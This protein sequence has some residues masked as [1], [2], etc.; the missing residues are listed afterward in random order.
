MKLKQDDIIN[1]KIIDLGMDGEG[2]GKIEDYILFIPFALIGEEVKAKV[3]YVKKN[4]VFC[5]LIEVITP[6]EDR[7]IP[8]CN[9]F[10]KCGG[11]DLLHLKYLKQLEWKKRS[12]EVLLRKNAGII[13]PV[14]DTVA[15]S[16]PNSYR[17]KIQLPFGM[18][19]GKVA[20]GFF[21]ENTHKIV[22]ITKCFLHGEWAEKLINIFISYA[23]E[24]NLS[25][26]DES[27]KK[28]ILR[29]MVA[30]EI[31]RQLTIVVVTN[32]SVLP[33]TDLLIKKL[34]SAFGANYALY[35]S[36]KKTHDNVIMG[37]TVIPIKEKKI[38]TDILG[39]KTEINPFS[40]LQLNNE[41][42]DKIY[43]KV[44]NEICKND[45]SPLVIDA[46]A[47]VGIIGAV[48]AKN[49]AEAYNIEIV[50]EATED[51]IKLAAE[52]NLKD[53]IT[54]INGDAAQELPK[55][56]NCLLANQNNQSRTLNIILDPPRKGCAPEVLYAISSLSIPHNVYYIS[57]NPATLSRD[58]KL[59]P[60]HT[61]NSITPYDMF[62][63]TKHLETLVCL[64]RKWSK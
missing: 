47:G 26:Y 43:L 30:R 35:Y 7:I 11:C 46:Y 34:D 1:V 17:N 22:S 21:R 57:C 8:V 5:N 53:K 32:N 23:N 18:V 4:L 52:N 51:G 63:N 61:I 38:V 41:I 10:M 39:I 25:V 14:D 33:K 60:T 50:K 27:T 36:P 37:D 54:N 49:G 13:F 28:G 20:M 15:C 2:I 48:L 64:T 40:F 44:I 19:N 55:L 16:T 6:S 62:P 12:L 3:T 42:R 9:R 31:D 45:I 58:L 24:N 29:H 59:L 56:I